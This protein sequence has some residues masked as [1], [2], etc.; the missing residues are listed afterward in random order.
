MWGW[1]A[2]GR[3]DRVVGCEGR[4]GVEK[5]LPGAVLL[6]GHG[7]LS[8]M[9]RNPLFQHADQLS[10]V[11]VGCARA[12]C[13]CVRP[14]RLRL[15]VRSRAAGDLRQEDRAP[16]RAPVGG[17]RHARDHGGRGLHELRVDLPSGTDAAPQAAGRGV[18]LDRHRVH[19]HAVVGVL[20]VLEP[21]ARGGV[22]CREHRRELRGPVGVQGIAAAVAM[23]GHV[24]RARG[25]A[26][27]PL[28]LLR[29]IGVRRLSARLSARLPVSLEA[30]ASSGYTRS[31]TACAAAC[32][33]TPSR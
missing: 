28:A 4:E 24:R 3:G 12:L 32:S 33:R 22:L 26:A 6:H 14:V 19:P 13:G 16:V 11:D 7:D 15:G 10:N 5:L 1:C 29:R 18:R 2:R 31:C 30:G 23:G 8:R 20:R 25:V 21:G 17:G 27:L 9:D